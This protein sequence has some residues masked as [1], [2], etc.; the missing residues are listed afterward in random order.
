MEKFF[1]RRQQNLFA[2]D[3]SSLLTE[4]YHIHIESPIFVLKTGNEAQRQYVYDN[5]VVTVLSGAEGC[6][7]IHDKDI[8]LYCINQLVKLNQ[9]NSN[10]ERSMQFVAHD[11]LVT[12]NRRTDGDNYKRMAASLLRLANTS[13]DVCINSSDGNNKHITLN[14][15]D[16]WRTLKRASDNRM[17]A[18]EVTFPEWVFAAIKKGHLLQFHQDYFTLRK[19]LERRIYEIARKYCGNQIKWSVDLA[20][21][22]AQSGSTSTIR[23][24]RRLITVISRANKLPDYQ[25]RYLKNG[26]TLK[27]Y[28]RSTRGYKAQIRDMVNQLNKQRRI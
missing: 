7:T 10:P 24:F 21:L 1:N 17:A 9:L 18:L 13:I 8:W 16:S 5:V 20:T 12:T 15:F 28:S 6:A 22:H 3:F 11:Y 26:D 4:Q 14:L 25:L 19:P 23:E 2:I 27:F